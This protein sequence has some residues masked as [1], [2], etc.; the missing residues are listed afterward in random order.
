MAGQM[1]YGRKKWEEF[2]TMTRQN[3]PTTYK[4]MMEN[5]PLIDGDANAFDSYIKALKLPA[6]NEEEAKRHDNVYL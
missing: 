6:I 2:E 4:S 1:T 5:L 3:I